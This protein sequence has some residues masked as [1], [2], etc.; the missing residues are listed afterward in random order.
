MAT[1]LGFMTVPDW[2]RILQFE[3]NGVSKAMVFAY[4]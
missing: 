2:H 4:A 1:L 3:S